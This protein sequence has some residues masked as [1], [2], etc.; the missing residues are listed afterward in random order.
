VDFDGSFWDLEDPAFIRADPGEPP[1]RGWV[2]TTE[3]TM[4]LVDA[5]HAI[6]TYD[7]AR[8]HLRGCDSFRFGVTP[9]SGLIRQAIGCDS[10][11]VRSP[12][13]WSVP[14]SASVLGFAWFLRWLG[15]QA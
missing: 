9:L 3:G 14:G 7:R 11:G 6:F 5:D 8:I 15:R 10:S 4:T 1:I 13:L 2:Q 12:P